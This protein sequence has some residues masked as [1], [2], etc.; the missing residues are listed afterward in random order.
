MTVELDNF[1]AELASAF[2]HRYLDTSVP[3]GR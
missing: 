1:A 3:A 2:D